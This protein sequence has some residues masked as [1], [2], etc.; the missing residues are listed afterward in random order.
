[1][2]CAHKILH[3][4]V[5]LEELNVVVKNSKGNGGGGKKSMWLEDVTSSTS[6]QWSGDLGFFF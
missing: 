1:M 6:C 5:A 3:T 4:T 2:P